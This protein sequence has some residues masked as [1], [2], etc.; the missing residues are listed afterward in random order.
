MNKKIINFLKSFLIYP[1]ALVLLFE[2][3]GWEP[4]AKAFEKL[5]KHPIFK[6]IENE[7]TQLSPTVVLF[8]FGIPVVALFPIKLFAFFLLSKGH[9]FLGAMLIVLAKIVGT[10]ICARLFQLTKPSLLK[11]SWFGRF[12]PKWKY[13]KDNL[14]VALRTSSL[15]IMLNKI[16]IIL[17]RRWRITIYYRK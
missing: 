7:I 4:L 2:E 3:W 11:I 8:I 12:Y 15:W 13:W 14:L 10:A 9:F 6:T 1:L 5:A 17:K 16:K